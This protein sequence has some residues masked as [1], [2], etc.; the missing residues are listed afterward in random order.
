MFGHML[1][2]GY[3][4][5][6]GNYSYFFYMLPAVVISMLAQSHVQT[7]FSRYS[8]M[9]SRRG[10][11]GAQVA[12][13][14]LDRNGLADVPVEPVAGRL[15]DNYDPR[16]GV[17]HLSSDVYGSNSVAAIG[18]A[19]HECGHAIQHSMQYR[20][21]RWRN[22]IIPLTRLESSAS[23]WLVLLGFLMSFRILALAGIVLFSFAVLFQLITLPVEFN[24]SARA[25]RVLRD[26]TILDR[27]ETAGARRV[28]TAAALTYVAATLSAFLNLAWLLSLFGNT[29]RRN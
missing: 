26:G 24:A 15:S 11:T 22:A 29:R 19:A 14:I 13:M 12:R 21:L 18:V 16:S 28:L 25:L 27:E 10:Y 2:W 9:L 1:G 4:Y 5:G 8:G 20:P 3:G 6:M 17:V 7:T 23:M